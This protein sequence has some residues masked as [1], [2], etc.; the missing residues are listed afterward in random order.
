M[1]PCCYSKTWVSRISTP[2]TGK[3]LDEACRGSS[4]LAALSCTGNKCWVPHGPDFLWRL[5]ALIHS[6]RLSLMKG[7]HADP[8]TTAWQEIGVESGFGLSGIPQHSTRLFLSVEAD[9]SFPTMLHQSTA[10]QQQS[11]HP[12]PS[13]AEGPAAFLQFTRPHGLARNLDAAR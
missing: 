4:R 2:S 7:A 9:S 5:V 3:S 1:I 11:C 12:D 6:M 10:I 8:S 13:E